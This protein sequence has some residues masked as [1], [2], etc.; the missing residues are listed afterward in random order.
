MTKIVGRS[1]KAA[2]VV[3]NEG[4]LVMLILALQKMEMSRR[5]KSTKKKTKIRFLAK[6]DDILK[7]QWASNPYKPANTHK[8]PPYIIN[9]VMSPP[10]SGGGHQNIFRF[11]KYLE[12]QGHTCRIYLYSDHDFPTV[13]EVK[14]RLVRSYPNTKASIEWLKDKMA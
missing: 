13:E 8:N 1:K 6:Y 7:A 2:R 4:V 3:K 9:W 14:S 12:D 5:R 11:I 10:Q